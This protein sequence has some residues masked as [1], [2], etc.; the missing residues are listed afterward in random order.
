MQNVP[1]LRV[2]QWMSIVLL[3]AV[4]LVVPVYLTSAEEPSEHSS[5]QPLPPTLPLIQH[6]TL[7]LFVEDVAT[8]S[9]VPADFSPAALTADSAYVMDRQSGSVLFQKNADQAHYPAS[10][11]KMMTALVV[12]QLYPLDKVLTVGEEAFATGST[13]HFHVGEQITVHELLKALLIPSG[14]DAAFVFANNHPQG[15]EGFVHDMNQKAAELHLTKTIFKNP[16]GLD[17]QTQLTTARD[18]AILANELMKDP[19]LREVV[20]T[21]Q[22]TIH[23]VTGQYAH[24]LNTTQELLGVVDGVVGVKTGTTEFAGENLITEI[25]RNG[26]QVIVVVLGSKSRFTETTWLINWLF[27]HYQ[28]ETIQ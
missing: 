12:R 16:S 10:T 6:V 19:I 20:G 3:L 7:P 5:V 8:P 1:K 11:A 28:W 23:D 27:A 22:T 14:N 25:D 2:D 21:R 26:H 24:Q 15:Y 13:V 9:A 17:D 4:F 18:L